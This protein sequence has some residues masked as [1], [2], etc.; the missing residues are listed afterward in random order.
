[1]ARH[2]AGIACEMLRCVK[3]DIQAGSL[4]QLPLAGEQPG[5]QIRCAYQTPMSDTVRAF[6]GLLRGTP[7]SPASRDR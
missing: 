1:M 6:V 5:M 4:V 3:D 2:G 7:G